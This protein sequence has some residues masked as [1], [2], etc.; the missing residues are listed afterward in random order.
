MEIELTE[1]YTTDKGEDLIC[2]EKTEKF[3][4]L[5]PYKVIDDNTVD[6]EIA[7]TYVYSLEVKDDTPV[8]AIETMRVVK[9]E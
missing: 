6:L 8:E 4:F 2:Y 9:E 5:C 1:T 7:R 3:A